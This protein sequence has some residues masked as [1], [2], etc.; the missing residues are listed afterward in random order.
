MFERCSFLP[1]HFRGFH[2]FFA[3]NR[4]TTTTTTT[5]ATTIEPNFRSIE[6][7]SFDDRK[8]LSKRER[9]RESTSKERRRPSPFFFL[10]RQR[11]KVFFSLN[12]VLPFFRGNLNRRIRWLRRLS[13][14][15]SGAIQKE[16]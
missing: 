1:L 11:K 6:R 12:E 16:G 9:E 4:L 3:K 10:F 13:K 5:A 14:R 8:A 2:S 7:A 15:A